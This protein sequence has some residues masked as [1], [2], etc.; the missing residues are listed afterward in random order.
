MEVESQPG[1]FFV[2]QGLKPGRQYKLIARTKEGDRVLAGTTQTRA[3]NA[4]VFIQLR[5]GLAS[6]DTPPIPSEPS[7]PG[8]SA[9]VG[10]AHLD[11]P[12]KTPPGEDA[13]KNGNPAQLRSTGPQW[14]PP[15]DSPA[16]S[17]SPPRGDPSNIA[18]GGDKTEGWGGRVPDPP[19]TVPPQAPPLPPAPSWNSTPFNQSSPPGASAPGP[20]ASPFPGMHLPEVSTP[21][22]SCVV[23]GNQVENFA[24]NDL[25]LQ[26]W[27][28]KRQR[29]GRLVLLDFWRSGCPPCLEAMKHLMQLHQTYGPSG[30]EIIGIAYMRGSP[31]EQVAAVRGVRARYGVTYPMLLGA[32]PSCPVKAQLQVEVYPTLVLLD[33][34]GRILWH[35]KR[36]GLGNEYDRRALEMDIRRHLSSR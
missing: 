18:H 21:V 11:P 27:E 25:N 1:G 5:E 12:E 32:G 20:A 8:K 10:S 17:N 9:S 16:G 15:S 2:V 4:R 35:S 30:L 34:Y 24:L 28:F 23:V 6:G 14:A 26:P 33:E 29:Q 3:P 36:N 7:V 22:P 13:S 31:V 19:V